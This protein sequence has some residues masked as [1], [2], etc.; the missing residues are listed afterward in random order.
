MDISWSSRAIVR[1]V[2]FKQF[3]TKYV[4]LSVKKLVCSIFSVFTFTHVNNTWMLST[5]SLNL[6]GLDFH[7][8]KRTNLLFHAKYVW[9]NLP[10][11]VW[12]FQAFFSMKLTLHFGC[13]TLIKARLSLG[14]LALYFP[15]TGASMDDAVK[16][17]GEANDWS[18]VGQ[19]WDVKQFPHPL[20]A[21]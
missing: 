20:S 14:F 5:P 9:E 15:K 8:G 7:S 3:S 4:S 16:K 11:K 6:V 1:M 2:Y 13:L 19:R 18:N 21:F 17:E 12:K 10:R